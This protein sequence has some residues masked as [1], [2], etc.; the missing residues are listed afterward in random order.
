SNTPMSLILGASTNGWYSYNGATVTTSSNGLRV[1]MPHENSGAQ[2]R[3]T[4]LIPGQTYRFSMEVASASELTVEV[5]GVASV[6]ALRAN[7]HQAAPLTPWVVDFVA[8]AG[9]VTLRV[10]SS[11]AGEARLYSSLV[12]RTHGL[13][14]ISLPRFI[15]PQETSGWTMT[16]PP[17]GISTSVQL[18]TS[19]ESLS[20]QWEN[21]T[22]APVSVTTADSA[23]R[24][25]RGMIPGRSYVAYVK[26]A[27][28]VSIDAAHTLQEMT[29]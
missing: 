19:P 13:L 14:T 28:L 22:G 16:T 29:G 6:T 8:P 1:Q 21:T 17:A 9:A 27:G 25:I 24:V 18:V 10:T 3:V 23:A 7:T 4:G 12:Q 5:A 26:T 2:V 20:L 11:G 15:A